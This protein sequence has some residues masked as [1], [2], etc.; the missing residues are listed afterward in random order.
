[1]KNETN[2]LITVFLDIIMENLPSKWML[3][4]AKSPNN[5]AQVTQIVTSHDIKTLLHYH[6]RR[7][8]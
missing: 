2:E 6:E 8:V 7:P 4:V 1:M 5:A 3:K